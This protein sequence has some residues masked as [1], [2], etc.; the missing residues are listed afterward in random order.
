L[1]RQFEGRGVV[2]GKTVESMNGLKI[3]LHS[4]RIAKHFFCDHCERIFAEVAKT[5]RFCAP[6]CV[7]LKLHMSAADQSWSARMAEAAMSRWPMGK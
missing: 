2:G 6:A 1:H 3:G 7:S 5:H 4:V